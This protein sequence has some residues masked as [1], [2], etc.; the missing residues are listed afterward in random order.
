M[1]KTILIRPPLGRA[2]QQVREVRA[3]ANL[4]L[5]DE[6]PLLV[7]AVAYLA[8]LRRVQGGGRLEQQPTECAGDHAQQLAAILA[9][10]QLVDHFVQERHNRVLVELVLPT[11]R[12]RSARLG[13]RR[14]TLAP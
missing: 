10:V 8:Q 5:A 6:E 12:T 2:L 3:Q 13:R 11:R 4:L 1:K 7:V 14:S 9:Q